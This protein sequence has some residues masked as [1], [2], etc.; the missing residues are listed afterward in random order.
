MH[1]FGVFDVL[2]GVFDQGFEFGHVVGDVDAHSQARE[3]LTNLS[4]TNPIRFI[5]IVEDNQVARL[6]L[7]VLLEIF[8]VRHSQSLSD[9]EKELLHT[10]ALNLRNSSGDDADCAHAAFDQGC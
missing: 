7:P 8:K 1:S 3:T 9:T 10:V 6:M 4:H 2:H 5:L